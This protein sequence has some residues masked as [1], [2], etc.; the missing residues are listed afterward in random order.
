MRGG[1]L[2]K[3]EVNIL[4]I[5]K[6]MLIMKKGL[7]VLATLGLGMVLAAC[8]K[9]SVATI[10]GKNISQGSYYDNM[11]NSQ[12]GHQTLQEMILD[13]GLE[14]QYG[15]KVKASQVTKRFDEVKAQ[16]GAT[17]K[18]FLQ[19]NFFTVGQFKDNLREQLLLRAAIFADTTFTPTMLKEQFKSYQPKVTVNQIVVSQKSLAAKII[20]K[21]E[22]GETF[23]KLAKNYSTDNATKNKDGRMPSFD[24]TDTTLD[25]QF[26]EAA[27]KLKNGQYTKKPVRTQYGYE[28]IQM[29]NHP[30]KGMYEQHENELKNQIVTAKLND[31]NLVREIGIKVLK[32]EKITIHDK[33]LKGVLSELTGQSY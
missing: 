22:S 18:P 33:S 1:Y 23:A 16:Y 20:K 27:F 24:N 17:F 12:I 5:K 25:P 13:K 15:N 32:R 7:M 31:S 29:V 19:Q 3:L 10:N 4:K 9:Q 6:W 11:K 8:G 28:V 2:V 30:A 26:K 14:E 21:L